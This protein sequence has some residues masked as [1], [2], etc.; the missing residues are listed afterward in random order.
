MKKSNYYYCRI[1]KAMSTKLFSQILS[2]IFCCLFATSVYAQQEIKVSGTVVDHTGE[3]VIGAAIQPVGSK[4]GTITDIDGNFTLSVASNA[5]L[6]VSYV[7]YKEQTVKIN[8]QTSLSIVLQ[9]DT[10]LLDEVVVIGYG[11]MKKRDLTGAISS[12]KS[13]VITMSPTSNPMEA[14]QGRVAGLDITKTS[15]QAGAG[16]NMQL[17]GTRSF[18]A[19]GS[20]LFLIDG[21][22]GDYSS[23]NP[24]DIESIEVLKDAS[25]TAIYGSSGSNGVIIITTK[26]AKEGKLSVNFNSYIGINSWSTLPKVHNGESYLGTKRLADQEAGKYIDDETTLGTAIYDAYKKGHTID[27]LDAILKTGI[28]QNY[29]LSLS[30]GTDKRKNYFSLNYSQEDGQYE[31]DS[32]KVFSGTYKT[33]Y[34]VKKWL[35]LGMNVQGSYRNQSKAYSKLDRIM[36]TSPYGELYDENGKLNPFPVAGDNRQV[37]LLLNENKDVYTNDN[38]RLNLYIT[39]YIRISPLKGLTVE[40]RINASLGYSTGNYYEGYGSYQYYDV[41]GVGAVTS[42]PITAN[43]KGEVNNSHSYN[44]KWENILTYNFKLFEDHDFTLTGVTTYGH[45]QSQSSTAGADGITSNI[46]KWTNL[47]VATGNKTIKSGYSMGK[48]MAYIGRLSYSYL[49]RYLL[50]ASIRHDGDSRLAK[51]QKWDTFPAINGGWRFSDEAFMEETKDWLDSAKIRAGYG[52]TGTAGIS[53]YDSWSILGQGNITL[54]GDKITS[55]Q[56]PG[57]VTNPY[58]GWE[59][60]YNTNIGLDLSLLKNRIE[61]TFDYYLTNTD[62]VIWTQPL[63]ITNGGASAKDFFNRKVNLASTRNKGIELALTTRNVETKEFNWTSTVTFNRNWEKVT[64]L[65]DG[66]QNLITMPDEDYTLAL[67][68]AVNSYYSHKIDGVWQYGEE[69]DAAVFGAK[70]GFLKVNVPGLVRTAE[71]QYEKTIIGDNGE[72]VT[73]IYNADNTYNIGDND[74]QIVGKNSPDWN[75]GF[76]NTFTWRDFDLSVYMYARF[77]QKIKYDMLTNYDPTGG[78]N[79]LSHFDYWTS[80]NASNDF[81]ALNSEYELKDY[82]GYMG[83]AYVDGSFF[84]IKNITLGYTMPRSLT[85]KLQIDKLRVYGTIT[86]PLIVAKS[87]L[88]K[89]YDPEMNGSLDFPLTRQLVFGVNF[90]F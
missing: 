63:P 72:P 15:G 55:Y 35:A 37:N 38:R 11:T 75:L 43:M 22:P 16:V 81:P 33:D 56:Y 73:T 1:G 9:E 66:S 18:T 47:G 90:S 54:G 31:R 34:Q 27:W 84:K 29:S 20:P 13:D 80:T 48:D 68:H 77:G 67:G 62:G 65:G 42:D 71:G 21:L 6:K 2:L 41:A 44:Y 3:P 76:Q 88:L 70:P 23:L 4:T 49:G 24:N 79:F 45:S 89:D 86:N 25:S 83:L 46:Y 8:N 51:G 12:V 39:P 17:R 78:K 32:Y 82:A 52:V 36:A 58:L 7:G 57:T 40:S 26:N 28:T 87:H 61:L 30:E 5:S 85:N 50:S 53:A 64:S 14:L 60:S 69:A 10:E 59:K 19:S 74:R